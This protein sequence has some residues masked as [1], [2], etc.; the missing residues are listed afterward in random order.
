MNNS[1]SIYIS[2]IYKTNIWRSHIDWGTCILYISQQIDNVI[3]GLGLEYF[4]VPKSPLNSM[5]SSVEYLSVWFF[6]KGLGT[7]RLVSELVVKVLKRAT[8]GG[9]W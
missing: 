6:P 3:K 7:Y 4:G 2:T 9:F 5:G 1:T 8:Y